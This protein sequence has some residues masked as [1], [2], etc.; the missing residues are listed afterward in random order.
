MSDLIF[1]TG[2][3]GSGKS[4]L[5]AR[6]TEGFDRV[7]VN[8]HPGAPGIA[9]DM[10]RRG[11]GD[12]VGAEL[13][14]RRGDY[15][16]TDLLPASVI[17]QAVPWIEA[18]T[19]DYPLVIAEG[20]RLANKRFLYA[21]LNS[22]YHVHLALLDHAD[23]EAWRRKRARK[24]GRIQNETWVKGRLTAARQLADLFAK[25]ADAE[26]VTVLRG[27]PDELFSQLE[28]VISAYG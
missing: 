9:H 14:F 1:I 17:D 15:A 13:G 8:Q 18:M 6:L 23:A 25:I 7:P 19:D 28:A 3:P 11:T 5:A 20:Q 22:G 10:L 16:G 26:N 12:V 2:Q 21:A 27:G 24:L 4:T